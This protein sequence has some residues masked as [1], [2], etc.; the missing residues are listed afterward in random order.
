MPYRFVVSNYPVQLAIW[1]NS[2]NTDYFIISIHEKDQFMPG[3][4][5]LYGS[6]FV[7]EPTMEGHTI[8][9]DYIL[10]LTVTTYLNTPESPCHSTDISYPLSQCLE[11]Y[12]EA[13]IKCR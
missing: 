3:Y 9:V 1:F 11:E 13:R 8:M 6:T 4:G 5:K 7:L 10:E 2:S 12:I